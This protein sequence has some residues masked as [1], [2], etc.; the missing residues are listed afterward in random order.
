[1]TTCIESLTILRF[2]PIKAYVVFPLLSII[3]LLS[4]PV[5]VY[6]YPNQKKKAFFNEVVSLDQATHIFVKGRGKSVLVLIMSVHVFSK[7]KH[8][9]GSVKNYKLGIMNLAQFH[10]SL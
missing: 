5:F 9:T 6:W 7:M 2:E 10:K 8:E 3:S 4:D 1:M